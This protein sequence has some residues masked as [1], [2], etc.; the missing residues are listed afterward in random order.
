MYQLHLLYEQ[1]YTFFD[2]HILQ[3]T[4]KSHTLNGTYPNARWLDMATK[5]LLFRETG[6]CQS[7]YT[8]TFISYIIQSLCKV[9]RSTR[10]GTQKSFVIKEIG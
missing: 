5:R 8:K 4:N 9:L 10:A 2:V 6:L 1:S 3:E 7:K